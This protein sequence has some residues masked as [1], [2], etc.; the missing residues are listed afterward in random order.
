ME[1]AESKLQLEQNKKDN[2]K[3]EMKKKTANN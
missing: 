2:K 1:S 3:W